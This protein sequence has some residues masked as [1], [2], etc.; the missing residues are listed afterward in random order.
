[1]TL[2]WVV[3]YRIPPQFESS[4]NDMPL[5]KEIYSAPRVIA[6]TIDLKETFTLARLVEGQSTGSFW[7]TTGSSL[8]H[9]TIQTA[10]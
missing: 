3:V 8:G 7:S 5:D 10:P 9:I 4:N 6:V 1:M 2:F